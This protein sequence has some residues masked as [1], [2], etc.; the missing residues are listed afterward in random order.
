MAEHVVVDR[1]DSGMGTGLILGIIVILLL[2]V[3]AFFVVLGGPSRFSG[4][5]QTNVN[6]P[7][8]SAPAAPQAQPQSGPNIN[9]P[10]QIDVNVNQRPAPAQPAP[11]N[12]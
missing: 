4:G 12:P 5:G 7:T 9:V 2:A 11:A 6:A 8:Q 1:G 3:V 10:G